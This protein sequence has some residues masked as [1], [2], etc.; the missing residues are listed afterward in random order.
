MQLPTEWIP[1]LWITLCVLILIVVI[2]TIVVWKSKDEIHPWQKLL[3]QETFITHDYQNQYWGHALQMLKHIETTDEG[4][5]IHTTFGFGYGV[6]VGDV[7][8]LKNGAL[9]ICEIKYQSNPKD[10]FFATGVSVDKDVV[11]KKGEPYKNIGFI[12]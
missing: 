7:L 6:K 3:E 9:L 10:M 11:I 2:I 8:L 1:E 4:W 12:F 5:L